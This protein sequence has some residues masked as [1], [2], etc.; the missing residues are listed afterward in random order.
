M[1]RTIWRAA[2]CVA[3]I[4]LAAACVWSQASRTFPTQV[5]GFDFV[6]QESASGEIGRVYLFGGASHIVCLDGESGHVIWSVKAPGLSHQGSP[7]AGPVLAGK[8]L[9]Y[10]GGGGFFTAYGLDT[11]T[12]KTKWVLNKR[13]PTLAAS[14]DTVFLARQ[15]GGGVIAVNARTGKI[16]WEHGATRVG[17]TLTRIIYSEGRLYTNSHEVW[18]T[19][20]G[21]LSKLS[22]GPGDDV[23]GALAA[24]AGRVFLTGYNMPLVAVEAETGGKLWE[25]PNPVP[26]SPATTPDEFVAA[27]DRYAVAAFYNDSAFEARRGVLEAYNAATGRRLWTKTIT[28]AIGLL[29]DPVS[30]D[31]QLVYL[32]EPGGKRGAERTVTAFDART[33]KQV[34]KFA[35]KRLNGPIAPVGDTVLVSS[36]AGPAPEYTTLYALHR[37]V[38]SLRWKFS[39]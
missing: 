18:D 19:G 33:G 34:W 7:G 17:G 5:K 28:S 16:K 27:S 11:Q 2:R 9:M 31:N 14:P 21:H 6:A 29:P 38:G 10:M 12:G 4:F 39:F 24:S 8:T 32:L 25:A 13:S 15:W 3:G 37:K 36:D 23:V 20:S 1:Y 22:F 26:S 35:A 30:V